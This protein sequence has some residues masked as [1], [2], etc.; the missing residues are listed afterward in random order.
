MIYPWDKDVPYR[1]LGQKV[2]G[3][4]HLTTKKQYGL[5][6]LE[7]YPFYV[8]SP[9]AYRLPLNEDGLYY[10]WGSKVKGQVHWTSK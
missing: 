4:A 7:H 3:Q 8:E 9:Y 2:K 5:Q 6:V 10:I 1:I